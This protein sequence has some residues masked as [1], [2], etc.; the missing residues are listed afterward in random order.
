MEI[1]NVEMDHMAKTI[2]LE[3][4]TSEATIPSSIVST[5]SM[6][7]LVIDDRTIH[8]QLRKSIYRAITTSNLRQYM[9]KKVIIRQEDLLHISW[10][11]FERARSEVPP[12]MQIFVTKVLSNT[13]PVGL[14]MTKRQHRWSSNCPRCGQMGESTGHVL[15]CWDKDALSTWEAKMITLLAWMPKVHTEPSQLLAI[16]DILRMWQKRPSQVQSTLEATAIPSQVEEL[17]Q[18]DDIGWIQFIQ[19]FIHEDLVLLQSTYYTEIHSQRTGKRWATNLIKNL[20]EIMQSMWKRRSSVLHESDIIN[21]LS[22]QEFL[23]NS[24]KQELARTCKR[25]RK[26]ALTIHV[27]LLGKTPPPPRAPKKAAER[28][29]G[30]RSARERKTGMYAELWPRRMFPL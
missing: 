13:L 5:R 12:K 14:V 28:G 4:I 24:I 25:P 8:S 18:Q 30:P 16:T 3:V 1:M 20:W 9:V 22:G 7:V 15:Q 27:I 21:S 10:T 19:G 2:A 6:Q 23:E 26:A 29:R 11:A 17:Q